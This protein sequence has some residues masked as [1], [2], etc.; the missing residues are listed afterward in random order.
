MPE[1]G[2][3]APQIK[4]NL[5]NSNGLV[6][7]DSMTHSKCDEDITGPETPG[8]RPLVPRFKRIQDDSPDPVVKNGSKLLDSSKRMKLLGDSIDGSKSRNVMSELNSKF[9]WLDPSQ[10]RDANRRRPNDPLYDRTTLYIPPDVMKKMSA[11]Q[12]QYW[13]VKSQYMDVVLFF[14]VVSKFVSYIYAYP[15]FNTEFV[16]G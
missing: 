8:M 14:K 13:S 9:E 7:Q 1:K 5:S 4:E 15:N 10:I 11:S 12:K 3:I 6:S 16:L 2:T